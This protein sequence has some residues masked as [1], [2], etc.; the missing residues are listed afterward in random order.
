MSLP[1]PEIN[2]IPMLPEIVIALAA[3]GLLLVGAWQEKH[4]GGSLVGFGTV[5]AILLAAL[6]TYG[7]GDDRITET[8]GGMFVA[9][10]FA[11]FMKMLMYAGAILPILMSWDALQR[12]DMLNGEYFVLNLFALLGGMIMASSGDFLTLYMGLEMMSLS[13]YV[14]AGYRRDNA[15]AN[16]A[17]L[18]YFILGSMASGLFLYGV[19]LIYGATGG[20]TFSGIQEAMLAGGSAHMGTRLGVILVISGLAFKVAAA[21]FHMWSPDV[22]EGSPTPVTAFMSALPKIAGFAAIYRV[23]PGAFA[24]MHGQWGAVLQFLSIISLAVGAFAA[25]PQTNIKRMLAYSSIGHVGYALIGLVPGTSLG[26]R[27]IL[28]YLAIYL[29][30]NMGAFAVV[31]VLARDDVGESIQDYRGLAH[32]RPL[33]AAVMAIFMFSMAGIPP[34]AGFIGKLHIFMAAVNGGHVG[35]A[36]AGVLFSAVAAFYYL[37][38]V[39]VMYFEQPERGFQMRVGGFSGAVL[40]LSTFLVLF[41]GVQPG[42]LL[43]WAE[44]SVTSFM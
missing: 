43:A 39:K 12:M 5:L 34:L 24:S 32:K 21:P 1:M 26:Y 42:R 41:W 31:L 25:I 28:I 14:L 30:M 4:G 11:S 22:Y 8:F 40:A 16:E 9:D 44:A 20:I 33:L 29:F 27:S 35:L 23:L 15:L 13:I 6:L 18:K 19:S 38:V 3:L 37:R 7:S 36:L 17:G 2:L 10:P